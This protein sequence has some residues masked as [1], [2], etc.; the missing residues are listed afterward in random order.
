ME[1]LKK[2]GAVL[3]FAKTT[4]VSKEAIGRRSGDVPKYNEAA[5]R[6][7]EKHGVAVNDLFAFVQPRH[8]QIQKQGGQPGN[9]HFSDEGSQLLG[10][11]VV[12][13]I[14]AALKRE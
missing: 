5:Q 14:E 1:R 4:P 11:Q 13:H 7:M 8:A 6:V 10:E 12:S 2:T 9:V 3:I